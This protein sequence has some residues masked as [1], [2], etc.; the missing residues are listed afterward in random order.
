MLL[1]GCS[2]KGKVADGKEIIYNAGHA[3]PVP[4]A[5]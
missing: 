2:G 4:E 1:G 3:E 5:W